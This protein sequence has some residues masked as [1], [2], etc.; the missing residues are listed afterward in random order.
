MQHQNYVAEFVF[1]PVLLILLMSHLIE[2]KK[3]KGVIYKKWP[4]VELIFTPPV[5]KFDNSVD[6]FSL[7]LNVL[8]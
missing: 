1:A 4:P 6:N 2:I 8:N 3:K 5:Q 7:F